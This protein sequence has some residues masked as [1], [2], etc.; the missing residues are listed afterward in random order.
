MI[1][2]RRTSISIE[3][4][5]WDGLKVIAAARGI[6]VAMLISM[7]DAHHPDTN[8]SSAIR[9]TVLEY[10]RDQ[11]LPPWITGGRH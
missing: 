6:T 2:G 9:S 8:L 3:D 5:F 4:A 7:I 1:N 11:N 10:Y